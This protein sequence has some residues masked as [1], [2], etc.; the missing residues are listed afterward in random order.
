MAALFSST[1]LG[2][3]ASGYLQD[4]YK[5]ARL[6][7]GDVTPAELL[8][9]EATSN[10]DA[11]VPDAKTL[12]C[13]AQAAFDI[14]DYWRIANV[15]HRRLGRVH[16]W[17]EW[18]P[19]YKA[20]VVLEFLLTHGPQELPRD[21][22]PDMPALHDLREGFNH[23]DDKGFDWGA[24]MQRRADSVI[25]LLTDEERLKDARRRAMAAAHG[26]ELVSSLPTM[27]V[28]SPSS[29]S[30]SPSM[31]SSSSRSARST[32]SF[33]GASPQYCSDSPGG[34]CLCS[35]GA[36]DYRRHKKFDAY[37]ADDDNKQMHPDHQDYF[38]N[39]PTTT[40]RSPAS[41]AFSP[42]PSPVSS[43]SSGR[44]APGFNSPSQAQLERRTSSKKLQLQ[45][46]LSLDY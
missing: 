32:W 27:A 7:L 17:K 36:G 29:S 34:G 39:N 25:N 28:S 16:D 40:P 2:R 8:V 6:A 10:K 3:Q 33:A 4:K 15:L 45:R 12:S 46:Q 13:I 38:C 42:S 24:S 43:R 20:L 19:V 5:Q 30:Y 11:C 44:R 37:T 35:P 14:D 9:Q 1:R 41:V 23:V 18:R 26:H 22:L 31:A 21:F